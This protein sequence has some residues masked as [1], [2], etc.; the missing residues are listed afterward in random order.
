[1]K[2]HTHTNTAL[3]L[4]QEEC[5]EVI[6]AVSK[7][8]RFGLNN[9]YLTD[10][11]VTISNTTNK[12][13]LQQEVGDILCLIDLLIEYNILNKDELTTATAAKREKLKKYSN[14]PNL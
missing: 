1:M 9:S 3:E 6:V 11:E 5:A 14:L 8:K 10:N 7:I 13:Q 4:L 2:T 12:H